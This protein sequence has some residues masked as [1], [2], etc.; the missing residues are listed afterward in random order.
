MYCESGEH[1]I[2]HADDYA[3][4]DGYYICRECFEGM[5]AKDYRDWIQPG[6]QI[7]DHWRAPMWHLP[8]TM[9]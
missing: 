1:E 2:H 9:N 7:P 3:D 5:T 6:D 8:C 4:L